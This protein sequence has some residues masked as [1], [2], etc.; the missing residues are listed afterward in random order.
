MKGAYMIT[1]IDIN[2]FEIY[3]VRELYKVK[4]RSYV[5][6]PAGDVFYFDHIDGSYSY[7]L[8]MFGERC[9]LAAW[10]SVHPLVKKDS[11]PSPESDIDALP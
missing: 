7:C 8:N 11:D 9:H 2:D 3:P 4:P 5:Q 1:A 6:V 10:Q